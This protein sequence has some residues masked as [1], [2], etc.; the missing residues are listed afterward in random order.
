MQS[1]KDVLLEKHEY[2][3]SVSS[4]NLAEAA[5]STGQLPLATTVLSLPAEPWHLYL[6]R[7]KWILNFHE[8][9]K[10]YMLLIV[11]TRKFKKSDILMAVLNLI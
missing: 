9:L 10:F 11:S 8:V 4:A 7:F 6:Q 3:L 1:R 5:T 2:D